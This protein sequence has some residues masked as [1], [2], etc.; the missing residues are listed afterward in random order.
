MTM[1]WIPRLIAALRARVSAPVSRQDAVARWTTAAGAVGIAG[2]TLVT[3]I[4]PAL[5][6]GPG[7][8]MHNGQSY[9]IISA[10]DV[11][12]ATPAGK[13]AVLP[14][15]EQ[16]SLLDT[17]LSSPTTPQTPS[18]LDWDKVVSGVAP[19]GHRN[20]G[21]NNCGGDCGGN[22]GNSSES[23][24]GGAFTGGGYTAGAYSECPRCDPFRYGVIEGLYMRRE[25]MDDRSLS[26]QF[27]LDEPDFEFGP[28]IT[29][30]SVPDCVNGMEASFTGPMEWETFNSRTLADGLNPRLTTPI[31]GAEGA[32]PIGITLNSF[33]LGFDNDANTD[34]DVADPGDFD[35]TNADFQSQR[36]ESLYWSGEVSRTMVSRDAAKFLIGGRFINL[37]EEFLFA[38]QNENGLVGDPNFGDPERG[39]LLSEARNRLVGMQVGLDLYTPVRRYL[40]T[41]FRGRAGL[42]LNLVEND[43]LLRDGA[44]PLNP[45]GDLIIQ[46]ENSDEQLAGMLELGYG[47]RCH[48]TDAWTLQ[49]GTEM[50]Y[51]SGVASASDQFSSSITPSFGNG[52]SAND[53]VVFLGVSVG[54]ECLY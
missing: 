42:F 18:G 48:L 17:G 25:G 52:V 23:V 35:A 20:S 26:A 9:Q 21:C 8:V 37:E 53:D 39:L 5:A 41:Y 11:T 49:A 31:P 47:F 16:A 51:L 13:A 43:I 14:A 22:C 36:Y 34:G 1:H 24:A 32:L 38:S 33:G 3:G 54:L 6:D 40:S 2:F 7:A 27:R 10:S 12:A 15:S 29:F 50:W 4:S 46:Q 19:V 28:R 44:T 45:G 30:G